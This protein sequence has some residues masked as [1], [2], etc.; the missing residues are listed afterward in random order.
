MFAFPDVI[1]GDPI[2]LAIG[3]DS[4]HNR[5]FVR[6]NFGSSGMRILF[7]L[8]F[9]GDTP[10]FGITSLNWSVADPVYGFNQVLYSDSN[11]YS[12]DSSTSFV[13]VLAI[14]TSSA[15]TFRIDDGWL[16]P[17][18]PL[19]DASRLIISIF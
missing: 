15:T 5:S 2:Y 12:S 9:S 16:L 11:S 13:S 19:V 6:V 7:Q 1:S 8:V 18:P 4:V 17:D 14:M 3:H 10:T